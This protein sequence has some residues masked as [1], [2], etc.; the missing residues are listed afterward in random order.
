MDRPER[1]DARRPQ[2]SR[3]ARR[4]LWASL[5]FFP[6]ILVTIPPAL[7]QVLHG[8]MRGANLIGYAL[9]ITLGQIL[10]LAGLIWAL[11]FWLAQNPG[12][13]D[14]IRTVV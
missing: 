8:K 3:W 13:R 7:V 9:L 6:A 12:L 11:T 4:S 1:F 10:V 2:E 5:V 14:L